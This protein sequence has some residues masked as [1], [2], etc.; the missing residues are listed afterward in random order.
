MSSFRIDDGR[1]RFVD[2]GD[3]PPSTSSS[4]STCARRT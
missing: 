4:A 3:R 1:L 2:R